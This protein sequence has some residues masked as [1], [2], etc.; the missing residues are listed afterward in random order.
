M[1]PFLLKSLII[2]LPTYISPE[3]LIQ[4]VRQ[5]GG[6]A[7]VSLSVLSVYTPLSVGPSVEQTSF[8]RKNN[9]E[10]PNT[11]RPLYCTQRSIF[12]TVGR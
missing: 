7:V 5:K 12:F 6:Q 11:K 2:G 3:L 10:M 4:S 8:Y 1:L 9:R